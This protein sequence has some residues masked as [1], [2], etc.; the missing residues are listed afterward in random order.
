MSIVQAYEVIERM[1]VS[2]MV[3]LLAYDGE[4]SIEE[5]AEDRKEKFNELNAYVITTLGYNNRRIVKGVQDA[6][7]EA[8]Q[9]ITEHIQEEWQLEASDY[10]TTEDA[11]RAINF[12]NENIQKSL[13]S[14]FP[15]KG[16]VEQ[17]YNRVIDL[18]LEDESDDEIQEVLYAI[19]LAELG[20]GLST[21]YV[22]SDG[23]RWQMD[24]YVN[25]VEKHMYRG[26]FDRLLRD[27]LGF[28]G[29]ELVKVFKYVRPRDACVELQNSGTICIVPR[30]E[31][32]EESLK[33]P[34][35]HDPQHK[36]L[37]PGGHHGSDANCRHEWHHINATENKATKL[38]KTL[39]KNLLILEYKRMQFKRMVQG[40]L[41]R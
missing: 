30:N 38:Y 9:L 4:K 21:G 19:M 11:E 31:A 40:L 12:L 14:V 28:H 41:S 39:D 3:E 37:Q 34:N 8:E 24:R 32:S 22:Q 26:V 15:Q 27:T 17:L 18:A 2:E 6:I 10:D 35:I 16:T 25:E 33:Y 7:A 20:K 23:I 29:V 36:Y 5:L 13:I 1:I